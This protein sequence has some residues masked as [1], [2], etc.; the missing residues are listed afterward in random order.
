MRRVEILALAFALAA[1]AF[2]IGAM[3]GLSHHAPR[4]VLRVSYHFGLFQS[5]L[6]L[7]GALAGTLLLSLIDDWDHWIVFA[8]LAFLGVRMVTGAF[9]GDRER[10]ADVDLTQGLALVG[11]SLAV[12]VDALAAGI[13]LPAAGA[14]VIWAVVVIG[15]VTAL[16]TL[17]AML[18]AARIREAVVERKV[19]IVAGIVLIALGTR[20]LIEHL[21][22]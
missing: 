1:D 7:L 15:I 20:F 18:L 12:S 9:A 14:P 4:Q 10:S 8:I 21:G 22:A 16:A 13:G 2:T 19:E 17:V 11:L 3:V 5:L 6:T